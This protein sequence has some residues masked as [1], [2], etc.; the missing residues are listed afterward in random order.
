MAK[1]VMQSVNFSDIC[2]IPELN[3]ENY[4]IWKERILLHLGRMNIDYAIRKGGPHITETSTLVD[5]ALHE[6][7]ERSNRLS[8]MSSRPKLLAIDEQ[9]ETSDKALVSI[10]IIKFSSTKLISVR[11]VREHIMKTPDLEAQWKT[12]EVEMSETFLVHYILNSLPQQ[13]APF[14]ISYNTYKDKW[15]I[16]ELLTMCVQEDGRLSM[17]TRESAFM[18]TQGKRKHQAKKKGKERILVFFLLKERP[19][20]EGLR[21]V[22][23]MA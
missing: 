17:E 3:G 4:K 11:G 8:T 18:D 10:L 5:I 21:Q 1:Q 7:C 23:E 2:Y 9:F 16:N 6:Q 14:N 13:Y 19:H 22:S 20:E 12:L 15:S